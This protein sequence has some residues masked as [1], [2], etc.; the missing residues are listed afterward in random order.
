MA[1]VLVVNI[2]I[3]FDTH[4]WVILSISITNFYVEEK[5]Y[6]KALAF[7]LVLQQGTWSSAAKL[8]FI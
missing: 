2:P 1:D 6:M 4:A 8:T 5:F 3:L 7:N